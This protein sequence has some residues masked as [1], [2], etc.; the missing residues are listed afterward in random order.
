M[1]LS[2]MRQCVKLLQILLTSNNILY[3]NSSFNFK[4]IKMKGF[5]LLELSMVVTVMALLMAGATAGMKILDSTKLVATIKQLREVESAIFNFDDKYGAY[6]GDFSDAHRYFDDGSDDICGTESQCN[7][8]GDAVLEVGDKYSSEVYR[9]WQ[10]LDLSGIIKGGYSGVWGVDD[11]VMTSPLEGNLTL[12]SE[13]SLG[14]IIKLGS[15]VTIAGGTSDGG[16]L[17]PDIAEKIDQKIDDNK[18]YKGQ[19]RGLHSFLG[20]DKG[21]ETSYDSNCFLDKKYNVSHTTSKACVLAFI[22]Y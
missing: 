1:C 2:L 22:L 10:H 21:S 20:G 15:I 18:P 9:A 11:Y 17:Y 7:G 19:V 3:I 5:S 6:P 16:V 4:C 8:D 13:D 12:I 14:N